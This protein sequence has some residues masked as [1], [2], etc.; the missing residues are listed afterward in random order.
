MS[1]EKCPR[2]STISRFCL[3]YLLCNLRVAFSIKHSY[4]DYK[5]NIICNTHKFIMQFQL[6]MLTPN[7][8]FV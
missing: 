6:W 4:K 1:N 8:D 2:T 5:S 3:L 7:I